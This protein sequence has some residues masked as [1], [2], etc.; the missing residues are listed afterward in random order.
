MNR[1][2]VEIHCNDCPDGGGYFVIQ[3]NM[4]WVGKFLFVCPKCGREHPREV[5]KG[6]MVSTPQE[7]YFLRD[8]APRTIERDFGSSNDANRRRI[9]SPPVAWSK[10]S[11]MDQVRTIT[12]GQLNS[13]WM[14]EA[15]EKKALREAGIED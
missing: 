2:P 3:M 5:K 1:E 9:L 8:K 6:E 7:V 11:R 15:W 14:R 4:N 13:Q 10:T 12:S